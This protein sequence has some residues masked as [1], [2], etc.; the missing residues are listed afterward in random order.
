MFAVAAFYADQVA[1]LDDPLP[2]RSAPRAGDVVLAVVVAALLSAMITISQAGEGLTVRPVAY[3]F[4]AGFGVVL[5]LRRSLPIPMLVLSV[6][7]TFAYYTLELPTIGVALPVAAALYCAAE[8]GV[9]RWAIGAGT[10]VFAVALLYRVRDDPQPLGYLLGTDAVTNIALIA[11]A[12]A[13]GYAVRSHRLQNAQREEITRLQEQ[14]N[15]R[16]AQLR[17]RD[18]REQISRELHDTVGHSLSVISLH[19][20]VASDAVGRD[21]AAVTDALAQVRTQATESLQELRSMVRLLRTDPSIAADGTGVEGRH[22]RSLADVPTTLEHARGAGLRV[23]EQV[24]VGRG[25]LSPAVDAAAYR[26]VQ[27]SVTNV[28]RHAEATTVQVTAGLEGGELQ[29]VITD[30]GRGADAG[31]TLHG[32]TAGSGVGLLGM[33]ER[34]RL[35]GGTFATRTAPGSGFTVEVTLPAKLG[36]AEGTAPGSNGEKRRIGP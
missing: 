11:G 3:L 1:A 32:L 13:L 36:A 8:Q 27:E 17:M 2:A 21:D 29:L 6:L 25:D 12:V 18:E 28:L 16:E 15:R 35:L 9:M 22:V 23:Q 33:R 30:D 10:T 20:G 31:S 5:L 24:D 19:T 26:V 34:V 4:A 7:G 14:R